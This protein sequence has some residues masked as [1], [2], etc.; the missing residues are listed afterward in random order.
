MTAALAV[1][2]LRV[3]A[4][5]TWIGGMLFIALVLVPITRRLSDPALRTRFV[6]DVG[7]RFRTIAWLPSACSS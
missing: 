1:R 4:A 7:V 6:R 3:L 5:I 2:F